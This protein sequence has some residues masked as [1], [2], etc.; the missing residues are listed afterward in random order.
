MMRPSN[1]P[2]LQRVVANSSHPFFAAPGEAEGEQQRGHFLNEW[3]TPA[4]RGALARR[5][6]YFAA[7]PALVRIGLPADAVKGSSEEEK[8]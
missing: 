5:A 6:A 8:P 3:L 4:Q 7:N 1:H 2:K